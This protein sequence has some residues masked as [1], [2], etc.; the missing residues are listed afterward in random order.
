MPVKTKPENII[1][2]YK[3]RHYVSLNNEIFEND[4]LSWEAK[5]MLAYLLSRP[6][7][8]QVRV[9][10]LINRSTCG[11]DRVYTII[12]ELR[13]AGHI[14]SQQLRNDKG[15]M[16]GKLYI[17]YEEKQIP[18][19]KPEGKA[20]S[21]SKQEQIQDVHQTIDQTTA[22][23]LSV[24]GLA[25]YG[26]TVC[27]TT[28]S[29][30]TASG[31]SDTTNKEEILITESNK[32]G[33]S[34]PN[35]E[36]PGLLNQETLETGSES[37][38]GAPANTSETTDEESKSKTIYD[39][40]SPEM[41]LSKKLLDKLLERLPDIKKPNMQ[42]WATDMNSLL[43]IDKRKPEDVSKVIDW[44]QASP[45]WRQHIMSP[46]KLRKH[47]DSVRLQMLEQTEGN[48]NGRR[49]PFRP[50]SDGKPWPQ[51]EVF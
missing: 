43:R 41:I 42:T 34:R 20:S 27:G 22:S 46:F 29:G 25:V 36:E 1:K 15:H 39:A 6:P 31:K 37:I 5:G 4:S 17:V 24:S 2:V 44:C 7:D 48:V 50:Q 19:K 18:E 3:T 23:G 40:E 26:D 16:A 14:I 49:D 47:Y 38:D 12:N 33:E 9:S 30:D 35:S 13:N 32:K 8:W 21:D 10:D 45:F 51:P 28:V 11:R